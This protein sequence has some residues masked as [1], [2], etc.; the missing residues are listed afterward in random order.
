MNIHRIALDMLVKVK[1]NHVLYMIFKYSSFQNQMAS[2]T[3][4]IFVLI[5]EFVCGKLEVLT[6]SLCGFVF[7]YIR[8]KWSKYNLS[9]HISKTSSEGEGFASLPIL[10]P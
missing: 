1:E 6:F 4:S 9:C 3:L 2:A 10:P 8:K 7:N 5:E